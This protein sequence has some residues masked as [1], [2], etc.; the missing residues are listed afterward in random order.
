M[1]CCKKV[2]AS[3]DFLPQ[4]IVAYYNNFKFR[5]FVSMLN[6]I[7]MPALTALCKLRKSMN[8]HP[9]LQVLRISW[10]IIGDTIS[11]VYS[12]GVVRLWKCKYSMITLFSFFLQP[13]F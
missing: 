8:I 11:A 4:C 13:H 1:H 7:Q 12:D 5:V 10:N 3:Y 9:I 2:V 6:A